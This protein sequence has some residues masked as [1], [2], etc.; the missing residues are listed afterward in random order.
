MEIK[1]KKNIYACKIK[2]IQKSNKLKIIN[3]NKIK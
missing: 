3:N 2:W 1:Y